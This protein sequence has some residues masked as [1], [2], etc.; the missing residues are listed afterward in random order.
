MFPISST[1][2][3]NSLFC[4]MT[5][6]FEPCGSTQEDVKVSE[7]NLEPIKLKNKQQKQKEDCKKKTSTCPQSLIIWGWCQVKDQI[8]SDLLDLKKITK[9]ECSVVKSQ[10]RR[11]H[12]LWGII[13][14]SKKVSLTPT[15]LW[16]IPR[17]TREGKMGL[18]KGET[19]TSSSLSLC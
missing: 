8:Q 10:E 16:M 7:R 5:H 19:G 2:L 12:H 1:P 15:K 17:D 6:W 18:K 14:T 4:A 11:F 3:L 13:N 9:P